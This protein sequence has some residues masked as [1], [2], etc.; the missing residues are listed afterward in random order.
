MKIYN[1]TLDTDPDQNSMYLDPQ[2]WLKRQCHEKSIVLDRQ[3][4]YYWFLHRFTVGHN[5]TAT[6][7]F[8]SRSV[9]EVPVL[10]VSM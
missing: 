5:K 10:K 1:K 3:Q 9:E 8:I 2:H 4:I 7:N 6:F